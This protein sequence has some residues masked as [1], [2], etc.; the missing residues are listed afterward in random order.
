[1]ANNINAI[2]PYKTHTLDEFITVGKGSSTITYYTTSILEQIKGINY[3]IDNIVFDY[4]DEIKQLRV[5]V[6][7]DQAQARYY[8]YDGVYMLSYDLYKTRDLAFLIMALNGV[9][10][11]IDF[12]MDTIYII[13]PSSMQDILS[14]IYNA[15]KEYI[16][17]NRS[18]IESKG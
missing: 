11:P 16:D 1:M 10:N 2:D 15:E 12:T 8:M 4:M 3:T 6:K 7:L 14:S 13:R 9:Y 18:S 17:F 5:K